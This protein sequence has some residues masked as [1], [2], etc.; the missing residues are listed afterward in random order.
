MEQKIAQMNHAANLK[1]MEYEKMNGLF[2]WGILGSGDN[3]MAFALIQKVLAA[4]H[5]NSSD[6]YKQS[7][8]DFQ[9]RVKTLR[10]GYVPGVIRHH[11][12]GSKKNRKYRE[13]WQ[14][15]VNYNY[16]PVI[17]ITTNKDGLL[18]PTDKCPKKLLDDIYMYF[19]ERNEDEI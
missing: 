19:K 7:V 8:L 5:T 9:E 18:V 10:L 14:I 6:N 15:L 4:I 13:R 2:D 17:H 11:F 3:I 1:R 16:D 12:H